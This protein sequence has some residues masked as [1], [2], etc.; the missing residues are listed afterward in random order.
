MITHLK[1]SEHKGYNIAECGVTDLLNPTHIMI[2]NS[3]NGVRFPCGKCL[4]IASSPKF[5]ASSQPKPGDGP[6]SKDK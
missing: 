5:A 1:K 3:L 4:R 2:S 6:V